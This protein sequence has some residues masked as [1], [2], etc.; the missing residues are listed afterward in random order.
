MSM[1][2]GMPV[3]VGLIVMMAVFTGWLTLIA[4]FYISA[5]GGREAA[6]PS[7]QRLVALAEVVERTPLAER[8]KTARRAERV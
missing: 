1:R 4:A 7:A 8:S 3:R 2:F 5:G 6:L